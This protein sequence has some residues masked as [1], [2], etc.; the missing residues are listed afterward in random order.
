MRRAFLTPLLL[1]IPTLLVLLVFFA[2]PL[3]ILARYSFYKAEPGGV[4]LPAWLIENY[5][6]FLLD[7]FYLR[8]LWT[9]LKL[10]FWVTL[11]C[12]V[13]GYPLAYSLARTRSRRMRAL[14][15]TILLIPLMTSV[16][17]RTYGWMILLPS[18]GL[19]NRL[20]LALGVVREPVRLMFTEV[21]VVVALSEVLLPFMVLSISPVLQSIDPFLEQASQSLGAGPLATL[22]RIVLPLSMPGVAAGSIVVFVLSISAFATPSLI[23]GSTFLVMSQ[24]VYSQILSLF[25][26]PFGAAVAIILLILVLVLSSVQDRF[27][28]GRRSLGR[29]G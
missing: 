20:L 7:T 15:I 8:I 23:G 4:M 25:N 22:W 5:R 24:F 10:G 13:L 6:R 2:Y 1:L 26:W 19:I 12:L 29:V 18:S 3:A 16:V 9:T 11:I 28:G 14:G 27:L 17:V 21:G